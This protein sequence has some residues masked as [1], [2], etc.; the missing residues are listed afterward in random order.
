MYASWFS[1]LAK[2]AIMLPA[3]L[4]AISF[5][6]CSHALVAH[7]LGDDTAKQRG[8]LTLNPF[9]HV[10]LLGII[11]LLIFRIGWAQPVPMDYRNFKYP[12]IYAII[13]ALAG[14]FSNFLLAYICFLGIAHFPVQLFAPAVVVSFIQVFTA[15]AYINI[16]L[17]A[18]NV[19]PIPPLD[20]S[21]IINA[22]LIKR[23]P[24][25]VAWL[26]RY[27]LIILIVLFLTPQFQTMLFTLFTYTEHVLK[28][29]VF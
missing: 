11:F 24:R 17:G 10:D 23:F 1:F 14:P 3:F 18:F 12:R 21:H 16:M 22:L 26:Y 6:E 2:V 15:T 27:S 7:W 4:I 25:A 5:H 9:A 20:G 28:S 8:R 29:L 13:A 19:L